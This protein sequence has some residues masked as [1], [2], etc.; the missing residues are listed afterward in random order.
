MSTLSLPR[1]GGSPLLG[2]LEVLMRRFSGLMSRWTML[3]EWHQA[4]AFT[5]WQM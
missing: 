5:N 1:L 2:G 3:F 4:M